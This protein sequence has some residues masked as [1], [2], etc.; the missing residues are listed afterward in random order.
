[1]TIRIYYATDLHGSD[2]CWKKFV[3]AGKF[4]QADIMILGGDMTGKA[5]IPIIEKGNCYEA[6]FEGR[7]WVVSKE[8]VHE[9]EQIINDKGYYVYHTTM[10]EVEELNSDAKKRDKLFIELMIRKLR[11]WIEFADERLKDSDIKCFVCPGNDDIPEIDPIIEESE[12]IIHAGEKVVEVDEYH[13]ML[14]LGWVNPSPWKT[15]KECSEEELCRKID[16]LVSQVRNIDTCI[17]NLHAPPYG[18]GLDSAPQIDK[19][20][21]SN[22]RVLV[23]VGSQAVL[24]AIEK[25]QPLLGLHGHIHEAKA[26][27]K[28]GR[29][30]CINPGSTYD[31]GVLLGAIINVDKERVKSYFPVM[32]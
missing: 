16:E 21:K 3:N 15:F 6:S 5:I 4:Y 14:G 24:H 12:T 31:R 8:K 28:I 1:M 18:T 25:Y 30:L 20:L 13:E 10:D 26:F 22:P 11:K 32:G 19:T 2:I 27:V 7:K 9:L 23:P 17:F 29:T